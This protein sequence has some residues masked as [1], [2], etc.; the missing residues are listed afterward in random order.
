M[1]ADSAM[2]RRFA[3]AMQARLAPASALS[4]KMAARGAG[5][6][7]R[8]L[9]RYANGETT[10][11]AAALG[12]LDGW[13]AQRRLEGFADEVLGRGVRKAIHPAALNAAAINP[14]GQDGF[15]FVV[16]HEGTLHSAP[17]GHG[18]A[19]RQYIGLPAHSRADTAALGLAQLGWIFLRRAGRDS[20]ALIEISLDA[21]MLAPQAAARAAEWLAEQMQA[22]QGQAEQMLADKRQAAAVALT[23]DGK[24]RR[25][26]RAEALAELR[27][28]ADE[29]RRAETPEGWNSE[30]LPGDR[31]D[32]AEQA[33]LWRAWH[34]A[35][36]QRISLLELA[37]LSG[38]IAGADRTALF[39]AEA[40]DALSLHLGAGMLVSRDVVGR[41]VH[42]RQDRGYAGMLLRDLE[43]AAARPGSVQ[44]HSIARQAGGRYRRLSLARDVAPHRSEV[45]TMAFGI[46]A[47]AGLLLR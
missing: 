6:T 46:E 10:I 32:T 29:R 44:L 15:D 5:C 35:A 26:S 30:A 19:V 11:S 38:R 39:L 24:M 25:L 22:E 2:A 8:T 23:I 13:F 12:A 27:K 36:A 18:A 28:L 3:A 42:A 16:T 1:A 45:L 31:L 43:A 40:G 47:P 9:E 17:M 34:D 20:S 41:S 21:G 4:L 33:A 7:A 37:A 14:A